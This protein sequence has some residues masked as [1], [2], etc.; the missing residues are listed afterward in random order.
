MYESHTFLLLNSKKYFKE[1]YSNIM[2][3]SNGLLRRSA[4]ELP[5]ND[6]CQAPSIED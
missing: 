4:K 3:V 5:K 2:A 6:E 1:K